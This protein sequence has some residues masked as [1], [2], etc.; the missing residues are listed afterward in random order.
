M[1]KTPKQIIQKYYGSE[2][3]EPR[4]LTLS[5]NEIAKLIKAY[6]AQFRQSN[7]MRIQSVNEKYKRRIM[8]LSK[9]IYEYAKKL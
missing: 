6:H 9:S 8:E 7:A 3:M 2:G 1:V 4:L 5:M